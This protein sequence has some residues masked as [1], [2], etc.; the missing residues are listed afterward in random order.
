MCGGRGS[1]GIET[2]FTLFGYKALYPN[3]MHLNRGNHETVN[4]NKIYGFEGEVTH[5]YSK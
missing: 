1:F 3:H 5:K 2:I 4:M